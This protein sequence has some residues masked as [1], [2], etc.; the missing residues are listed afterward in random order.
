[1]RGEW[2]EAP[3]SNVADFIDY[4]GKTPTKTMCGVPL[5]TAKLIKNNYIQE[6]EEFIAFDNYDSWMTRGIP[7]RGA[8]VFTTEAPLGKVAQIRTDDR[9]AFAQRV[10]IL[11]AHNDSLENDFL[12]YLLQYDPVKARIQVRRTGTTVFGIKSAELKKVSVPLPPLPTQRAIAATLS[13]L[14][15]KIE[16]NNRINKKLEE[17][18]QAIFKSWFVDFEPT[19]PFTEAVQV[20]GGGTPKTGNALFWNG[21]IP[22]FTP[23]DATGCYILST[24]KTL[25]EQGINNCNSQ[26]FPKNTVF[27]TARGTVGK[28]ALAAVPMA[29]NQSCYALIGKSGYG[30]YFTYHLA[31][32]VVEQLK[33]KASGAVFDA[34]VTRDFESEIVPIPP[35]DEIAAFE[36]SA[37]PIYEAILNNTRQS[38]SLAALRDA[39]LPRLMSGELQIPKELAE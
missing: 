6:P 10:I 36:E 5:V 29:M 39:L 14:D 34:I 17:M 30:Q 26:L 13:C 15:D 3:L 12:F 2:K 4:R 18:A 38:L 28:L 19:Q 23:K 16:L 33:K 1:M 25:T 37:T 21:S 7:Q 24:E 31:Q 11:Q 20:L 8:I 32:S 35:S 27:V 9:L 22:F